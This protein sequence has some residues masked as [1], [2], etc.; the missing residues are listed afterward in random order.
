MG[1]LY[2]ES[3]DKVTLNGGTFIAEGNASGAIV[4]SANPKSPDKDFEN[5]LGDGYQYSEDLKLKKA[6][7]KGL[8]ASQKT[9]SVIPLGKQTISA[10][11]VIIADQTA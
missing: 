2:L 4:A 1:G 5:F 10:A 9:I 7:E 11:K 8:Y 3:I 6:D